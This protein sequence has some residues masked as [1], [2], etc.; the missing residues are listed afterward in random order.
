[1]CETCVSCCV[2]S[3]EE[4]EERNFEGGRVDCLVCETVFV[5]SIRVLQLLTDRRGHCATYRL[6]G[7][8]NMSCVFALRR[9]VFVLRFGQ[10]ETKRG[11]V[12]VFW[13]LCVLT[14]VVAER[15]LMGRRVDCWC[16][17]HVFENLWSG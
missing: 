6:F 1:M 7:L 15:K 13:R 8:R 4:Q 11:G 2:V 9:H 16:A 10:R 3:Q 14:G 17:R 12:G 5:F